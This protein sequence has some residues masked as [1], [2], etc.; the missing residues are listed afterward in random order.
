[1][2][3]WVANLYTFSYVPHAFSDYSD[4]MSL[5]QKMLNT[6]YGI[7]FRVGWQFCFLPRTDERVRHL[8]QDVDGS[9]LQLS[10]S[11]ANSTALFLL[12]SHFSTSCHSPLL[13]GVVQDGGLRIAE[14][15]GL[16]EVSMPK[17]QTII[18]PTGL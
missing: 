14:P 15:K 13:P 2:G 7:F 10:E 1:M 9:L 3:G 17:M 4:R 16:P 6:L 18:C 12:N 5:W 8:L 11:D